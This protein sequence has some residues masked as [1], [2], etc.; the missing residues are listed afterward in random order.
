M[1]LQ[2]INRAVRLHALL[3]SVFTGSKFCGEENQFFFW[4]LAQQSKEQ[5]PGTREEQKS[6]ELLVSLSGLAV[7]RYVQIDG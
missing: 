4:C 6:K 7:D 5:Q 1:T 2:A 3:K